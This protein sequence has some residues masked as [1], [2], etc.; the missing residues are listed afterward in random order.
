[1]RQ[2]KESERPYV[3]RSGSYRIMA[4]GL[5][6]WQT[7]RVVASYWKFSCAILIASIIPGIYTGLTYNSM[8]EK[9]WNHRVLQWQNYNLTLEIRQEITMFLTCHRS[10]QTILGDCDNLST[11]ISLNQ[12]Q[13]L[14]ATLRRTL[15]FWLK[16]ISCFPQVYSFYTRS[17]AHF[18]YELMREGEGFGCNVVMSCSLWTEIWCHLLSTSLSLS[19][20]Y[21]AQ[22]LYTF[23]PYLRA[24]SG[25][26]E[27]V[28][29]ITL[30]KF[31]FS[32]FSRSSLVPR[33]NL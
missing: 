18:Q 31:T 27:I 9:Q 28:C 21:N 5:S 6:A 22:N 10:T 33:V 29:F 4:E 20:L 17:H 16:S 24:Y 12:F 3:D 26:Y 32:I 11:S 23:P 25:F 8:L 7:R 15:Q 2:Q 19:Y 30:W 14:N 13:R 1:M